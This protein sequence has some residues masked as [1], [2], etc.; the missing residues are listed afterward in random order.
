MTP[1]ARVFC[2]GFLLSAR[3]PR[4]W[5][6]F[7]L[8]LALAVLGGPARLV[9]AETPAEE[10]ALLQPSRDVC[11]FPSSFLYQEACICRARWTCKG[12]QCAP[13]AKLVSPSPS[14]IVFYDFS[15]EFVRREGFPLACK[16]DC[17]CVPPRFEPSNT[18]TV[19]AQPLP[20]YETCLEMVGGSANAW[21]CEEKTFGMCSSVGESYR[22]AVSAPV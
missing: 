10:A 21:R 7:S 12:P 5:L 14:E 17:A 19:A 22:Q 15:G 9:A 13:A 11:D 2:P 1:L 8:T 6:L 18:S 3:L 4:L 16:G 20:S